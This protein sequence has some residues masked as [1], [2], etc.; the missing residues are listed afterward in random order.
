MGVA[1]LLVLGAAVQSPAATAVAPYVARGRVAIQPGPPDRP[2]GFSLSATLTQAARGV[3]IGPAPRRGTLSLTGVVR[4]RLFPPSIAPP[5][6]CLGSIAAG[7]LSIS[8]SD[9]SRSKGTFMAVMPP[10]PCCVLWL[11][12]ITSGRFK[13]GIVSGAELVGLNPQPEPPSCSASFT[14]GVVFTDPS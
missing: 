2:E 4:S 12:N 14:G 3:A 1:G 9:G 13:G 5:N 11:G 6:L 10:D 8:W 7:G